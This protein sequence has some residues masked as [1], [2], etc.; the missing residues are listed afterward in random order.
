[1]EDEAGYASGSFKMDAFL[2]RPA[3]SKR[4]NYFKHARLELCDA[5]YGL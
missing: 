1:M 4:A 3:K 2:I 5:S